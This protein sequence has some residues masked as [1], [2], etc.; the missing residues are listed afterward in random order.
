MITRGAGNW[1]GCAVRNRQSGA[2][3]H[4]SVK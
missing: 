1:R 4:H 3:A 2:G